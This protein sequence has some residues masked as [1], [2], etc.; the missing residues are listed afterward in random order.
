M[1]ESRKD[2]TTDPLCLVFIPALVT[3]LHHLEATKGHALTEQEVLEAR[4]KAVCM[5]MHFS[6]AL[7]LEE[8]RGYRDIVAEKAWPEWQ[9]VRIE[10]GMT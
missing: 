4:D 1:T 7:A 5:T 6:D 2:T 10:L 8:S 3:L 9:R